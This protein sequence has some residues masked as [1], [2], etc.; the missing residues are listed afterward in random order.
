MKKAEL[1]EDSPMTVVD[2]LDLPSDDPVLKA[3]NFIEFF[4]QFFKVIF[5]QFWKKKFNE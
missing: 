2:A 5:D 4:N 1:P 3:N